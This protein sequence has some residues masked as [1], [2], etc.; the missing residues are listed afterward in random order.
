MENTLIS[1]D[2]VTILFRSD[3]G[4]CYG[5]LLKREEESQNLA[6][7]L[8]VC[9]KTLQIFPALVNFCSTNRLFMPQKP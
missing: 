5:A 6:Y 1:Y 4:L 9:L 8:L 2:I 3:R 7:V